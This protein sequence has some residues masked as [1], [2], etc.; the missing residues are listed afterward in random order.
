MS[1]FPAVQFEEDHVEWNRVA[2]V[3]K[4]DMRAII[5]QVIDTPIYLMATSV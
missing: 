4:G 5:A 2:L 1:P 3:M